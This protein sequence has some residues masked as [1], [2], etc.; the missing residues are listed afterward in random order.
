MQEVHGD[1]IA[2]LTEY[3]NDRTKVELLCNNCSHQWKAT[4]NN[5]LHGTGCPN[6]AGSKGEKQINRLLTELSLPFK[7][8]YKFPDCI[9][10]RPLP[11]DFAVLGS[12]SQ[13]PIL[14]IEFDGEQHFRA[15][16]YFGGQPTLKRTQQND[17]I[18]NAYCEKHSIP[19]LRIP[20]TEQ[21]NIEQLITEKLQQLL[22]ESKA[23]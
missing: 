7:A 10:E 5:L 20:Y 23:A 4:P 21:D 6:C 17:R 15:V 9:N 22:P 11:F 12:S 1:S 18:K 16:D 14:L 13:S 3:Q 8:Q 2:V 19:L